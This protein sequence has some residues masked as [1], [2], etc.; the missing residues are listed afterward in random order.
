MSGFSASPNAAVVA[1]GTT[2]GRVCV[3]VG[4]RSMG[5]KVLVGVAGARSMRGRLQFARST[6]AMNKDDRRNDKDFFRFTGC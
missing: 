3:T 1:R 2:L 5:R 6:A 4:M